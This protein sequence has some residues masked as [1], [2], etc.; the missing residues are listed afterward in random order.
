MGDERVG[1]G[2]ALAW[3]HKSKMLSATADVI[4]MAKV[5]ATIRVRKRINLS[6]RSGFANRFSV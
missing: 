4:E 1:T 2:G 3:F 5:R 6:N